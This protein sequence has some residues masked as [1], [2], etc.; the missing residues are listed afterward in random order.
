MN[1]QV[2]LKGDIFSQVYI[3]G[4]FLTVVNVCYNF[5]YINKEGFC[6]YNILRFYSHSL[7]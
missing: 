4:D 1:H 6:G 7:K 2:Y 5:A 3:F